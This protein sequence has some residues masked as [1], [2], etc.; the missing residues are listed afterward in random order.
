[1]FEC[2]HDTSFGISHQLH[3]R[4]FK[5][6]QDY[7]QNHTNFDQRLSSIKKN[8]HCFEQ[9]EQEKTIYFVSKR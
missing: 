5:L 6:S 1:M 3:S 4:I 7:A 8:K 9:L 2:M